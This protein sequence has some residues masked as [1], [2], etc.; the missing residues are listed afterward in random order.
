MCSD[1]CMHPLAPKCSSSWSML[2]TTKRSCTWHSFLAMCF[3]TT[4]SLP[5]NIAAGASTGA[6]QRPRQWW[7]WR[8]HCTIFFGGGIPPLTS[9]SSPAAALPT[10]LTWS[11]TPSTSD[12]KQ[13]LCVEQG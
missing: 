4:R 7:R 12:S 8:T 1:V 6:L 10:C 13:F 9:L 11:T 2:R 3:K 5:G